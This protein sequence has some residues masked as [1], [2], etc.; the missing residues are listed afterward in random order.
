MAALD[1]GG[2]GVAGGE[3]GAKGGNLGGGDDAEDESRRR[4]RIYLMFFQLSKSSLLSSLSLRRLRCHM[5][6]IRTMN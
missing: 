4:S 3:G 2:R 1:G 6:R 5:R